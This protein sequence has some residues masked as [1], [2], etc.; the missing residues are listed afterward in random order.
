MFDDKQP[1]QK[2]L[3][4]KITELI[5]SNDGQIQGAKVFLRKMRNI[6]DQPVNRF[7][8]VE[9]S[10]RFVLKDDRQG[11]AQKD[12]TNTRLNEMLQTYPNFK[13][14]Y[15]RVLIEERTVNNSDM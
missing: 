1:R 9:K 12:E 5:P 11:N 15:P 10:F 13:S 7:Y 8:P 2:W 6:I 14:S 4:G 3:F